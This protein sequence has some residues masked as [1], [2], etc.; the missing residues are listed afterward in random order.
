MAINPKVI[1]FDEP[2]S[3]LDPELVGEVL[4]LIKKLAQKHMTMVIVTHEMSFAREVADKVIFMSEGTIVESGS[5]E[6]IFTRPKNI[7]TQKFLDRFVNSHH[8]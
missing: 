5:P 8:L 1:L 6:E 3:A 7:R 4:A 2:T